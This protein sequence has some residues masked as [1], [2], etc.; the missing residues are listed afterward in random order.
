M[1]IH[2]ARSSIIR[3]AWKASAF[4]T[5]DN[6]YTKNKPVLHFFLHYFVTKIFFNLLT[7]IYI[8]GGFVIVAILANGMGVAEARQPIV[9]IGAFV[10]TP[11]LLSTV[12]GV[13]LMTVCTFLTS[14]IL[15][16]WRKRFFPKALCSDILPDAEADRMFV[17]EIVNQ[18]NS[19]AN[20]TLV[21]Y[22]MHKLDNLIG[23]AI[24]ASPSIDLGSLLWVS[25]IFYVV[26][27][28]VFYAT[29]PQEPM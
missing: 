22:L 6:L 21:I 18:L 10:N 17:G 11:F 24:L 13:I 23:N 4:R 25:M 8:G 7:W 12:L 2:R 19:I 16:K 5:S 3:D 27:L 28:A 9:G 14:R 29:E 20:L 15:I 26:G 1:N